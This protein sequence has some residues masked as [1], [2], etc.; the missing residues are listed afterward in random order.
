[1]ESGKV[2]RA[3]VAFLVMVPLAGCE[4][5]TGSPGKG[6]GDDGNPWTGACKIEYDETVGGVRHRYPELAPGGEYVTGKVIFTCD[7]GPPPMTQ[8]ARLYLQFHRDGSWRQVAFNESG[9]VPRPRA[10]VYTQGRC[11][12]GS[13]RLQVRVTGRARGPDGKTIEFD[14]ED[15]GRDRLIRCG[16]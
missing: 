16:G 4:P 9:E 12:S 11:R 7:Q 13:W 10:T 15:S 5:E 2:P 1:M 6:V 3:L 14:E 8:H